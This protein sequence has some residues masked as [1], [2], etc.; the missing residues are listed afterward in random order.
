MNYK[1]MW[2]K[3]DK[4]LVKWYSNADMS[5]HETMFMAFGYRNVLELMSEI[6]EEC[7]CGTDKIK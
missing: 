6:E 5:N 4:T 1:E 3:L 7:A 2:E